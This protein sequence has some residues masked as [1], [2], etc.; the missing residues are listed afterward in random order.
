MNRS[1]IPRIETIAAVLPS[2]VVTSDQILEQLNVPEKPKLTEVTGIRERRVAAEGTTTID[3]ATQAARRA[4]DGST[5]LASEIDLIIVCSITRFIEPG[6]VQ[7]APS[8]ASVVRREIGAADALAFDVSNAC[9]GMAT[10]LVIATQMIKTGAVTKALIVSGEHI[11]TISETAVR[12]ISKKYDPQF[13]ALTVGD[14]SCALV[15]DG[16]GSEKERIEAAAVMTAAEAAALCVGM[17]SDQSRG[18]AMYTDN[19]RMHSERRYTQGWEFVK[20]GLT[21]LGTDMKHAGYDF[22]VHHQFSMVANEYLRHLGENSIFETALPPELNV[23]QSYGNTSSTA[24][25]VVL[26]EYLRNGTIK[27]GN[28]VLVVP[29]ASGM[30]HGFISVRLGEGVAA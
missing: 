12:E 21:S 7:Y 1:S 18:V 11:T 15:L 9:A 2:A 23:M 13:A 27:P 3:L 25:F 30:V 28:R 26:H 17:P 19:K 5:Y 29:S 24:I 10:G 20:R 4:V 16:E 8:L 6:V 14:S 22:L